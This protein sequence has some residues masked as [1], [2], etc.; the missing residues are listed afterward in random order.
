MHTLMRKTSSLFLVIVALLSAI[1]ISYGIGVVYS[2]ESTPGALGHTPERWPKLSHITADAGRD[3]LVMLVHPQCSCTRA[4][5]DELQSIMTASRGTVSAWVLFAEPP[6]M[7]ADLERSSTWAQALRIPNVSV[8]LDPNGTEAARFGALTSGH[9]VLY[10]RSGALLFS[11]GITA[12]RGHS[13]DNLGRQSVRNLLD[14]HLPRRVDRHPV[15]GCP[16]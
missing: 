16:L 3:S 14:G 10:D 15:Y 1:A 6:G 2:F 7:D 8:R 5:L 4:S 9:V 13:G 11:G 12:M